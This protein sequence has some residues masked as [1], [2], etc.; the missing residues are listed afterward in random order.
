[1]N[2]ASLKRI[3]TTMLL[4]TLLLVGCGTPAARDFGGRWHPVNRFRT[5]TTEIPLNRPYTYYAAP[6]DETLRNMLVRWTSDTG[7]MLVYRIPSDY[8]LFA[9]V[10]KVRT[11]DV[12]QAARELSAIYA[13]QGV[14]VTVADGRLQVDRSRTLGSGIT[15][16]RARPDADASGVKSAPADTTDGV[17]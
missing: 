16:A 7:M 14:S 11:A 4:P 5:S 12:R 1:M 10:T 13:T 17:R 2:K 9:P 8:T 3:G 15:P 6:M